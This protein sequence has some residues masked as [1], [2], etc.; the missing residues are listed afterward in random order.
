MFLG[1]HSCAG[2]PVWKLQNLSHFSSSCV[3]EDG[4]VHESTWSSTVVKPLKLQLKVFYSVSFAGVFFSVSNP[5][6]KKKLK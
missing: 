3:S 6:R 1:L 4:L 2:T 5:G